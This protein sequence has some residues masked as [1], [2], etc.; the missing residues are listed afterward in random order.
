MA[1]LLA[2]LG[3]GA[4]VIFGIVA[5][6]VPGL[7]PKAM[8]PYDKVLHFSFFFV[9]ALLAGFSVESL[10]GALIFGAVLILGGMLVEVVQGASGGGRTAELMDA[11]VNAAGAASGVLIVFLLKR[12]GGGAVGE[13]VDAAP[14]SRMIRTVRAAYLDARSRAATD[15]ECLRAAVL[16][17]QHFRPEDDEAKARREIVRMLENID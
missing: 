16:A 9:A 4:M 12:R 14:S 10:T 17:Y 2:R 5:L 15:K 6:F 8:P 11:V 1:R 13:S 3:I 7:V